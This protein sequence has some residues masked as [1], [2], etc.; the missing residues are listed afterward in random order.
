MKNILHIINGWPS[1]GI[2]EQTYLLCKHL[3]KDKFKQFSIGYCHFDGEFV[4][5]FEDV[6]VPCIRSD[7]HYTDII[8]VL[9]NN[10]IDIIHKQTGGGDFPNWVK[11]AKNYG[12]KIVETLHCPR[13]SGI[14]IEYLD[15][16]TYTTDYTYYKNSKE[17]HKIMYDIQYA[18]DLKEPLRNEPKLRNKDVIRVGR[19]G[20][21]VADKRPDA[22]L[23]LARRMLDTKYKDLVVFSLAGMIPKDNKEFGDKFIKSCEDLPNVEYNG[24]VKNKYDFWKN[25]DICV[26][27]VWETSFDIV[28]LEAMSCGIP[29]L[30]WDNSASKYV[31]KNAGIITRE[32]YDTFFDGLIYLIE[33]EKVCYEYAKKGIEYIKTIYSLDNFI[34]NWIDLYEKISID[35]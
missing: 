12:I 32:Y 21:I 33:N 3:P 27:P 9:L 15:A 25:L 30:T 19:L 1:G 2:A 35:K 4:K 7:Y 26:N 10:K 5:K 29:I 24:F 6:G 20:R 28:F 23:E 11:V 16:I 13:A 31:V 18:L 22:I 14:P 8:Q 17:Y 34:K